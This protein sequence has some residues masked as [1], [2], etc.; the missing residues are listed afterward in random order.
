MSHSSHG[1]EVTNKTTGA[2]APPHAMGGHPNNSSIFTCSKWHPYH[3][4]FVHKHIPTH[5]APTETPLPS[6]GPSQQESGEKGK[7]VLLGQTNCILLPD[8]IK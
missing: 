3:H 4:L 2:R 8:V 6:R 5:Q 7:D 1:L